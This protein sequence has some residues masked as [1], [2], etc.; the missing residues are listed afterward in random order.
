M[1]FIHELHYRIR[2]ILSLPLSFY[3]STWFHTLRSLNFPESKQHS[4]H[5]LTFILW[6]GLLGL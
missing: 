1:K 6:K 3:L 5:R 2:S 4:E